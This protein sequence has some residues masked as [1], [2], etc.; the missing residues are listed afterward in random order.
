MKPLSLLALVVAVVVAVVAREAQLA[1]SAPTRPP[2]TPNPANLP[3][4]CKPFKG[5]LFRP[6]GVGSTA[7]AAT[8]THGN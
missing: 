6:R 4:A 8:T 5:S 2:D 3:A 1:A 7:A